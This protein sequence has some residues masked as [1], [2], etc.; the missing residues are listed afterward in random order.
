MTHYLS[1]LGAE[2]AGY[3]LEP[4]TVPAMYHQTGLTAIDS[5]IADIRDFKALQAKLTACK[6][7]II[8]HMAAQP[9]V[10]D[11]YHKPL[12]TF[13]INIMGTVNLL[14][15]ARNS[16]STRVI[17]VVTTDKCYEN[18][19]DNRQAFSEEDRLGGDEPY[20]SSKACCELVTNSY[21]QTY[22]R[23]NRVAVASARAGNVIGGGDWASWRLIPDL[24]R[25]VENKEQVEIRYPKSVRP[26]QHVLDALSGYLSLAQAL[27]HSPEQYSGAWNFGPSQ[28]TFASVEEVVHLM[29][30]NIPQIEVSVVP[31]A[32]QHLESHFLSLNSEKAE[33]Y[34]GW[35]PRWDLQQSLK[36]VAQWYESYLGNHC[37]QEATMKQINAF[38]ADL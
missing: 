28:K 35:Y 9:I 29:K 38:R 24:I 31:P 2:T 8:F 11:A 14:E 33:K 17:I 12:E 16:P 6:P 36:K 19:V 22:F 15:A 30:E 26:W 18:A 13:D 4:A 25:A 5:T 1:S 23:K 37:L 32:L 21:Y 20:G 3:A 34:L 10:I 7:E 27:Y